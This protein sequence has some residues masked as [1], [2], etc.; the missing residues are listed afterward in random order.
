MRISDWSSDVCSSDLAEAQVLQSI[1]RQVGEGVVDHQVIHV[2]VGDAGLVER[3]LAR[4]AEG[5]GGIEVLHLADH[6]SL[7]ALARPQD[8]DR[9]L[10]SEERRVGKSETSLGLGGRRVLKKKNKT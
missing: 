10:R 2:G 6:R 5:L 1:E 9:L 8:V 7:D 3:L 4:D